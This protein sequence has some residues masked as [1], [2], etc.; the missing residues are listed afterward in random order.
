M[1][2]L[3]QFYNKNILL[4]P[5]FRLYKHVQNSIYYKITNEYMQVL[6]V[7]LIP[8]SKSETVK[9]CSDFSSN[10][11]NAF[12]QIPPTFL[13]GNIRISLPR[14]TPPQEKFLE[15]GWGR[16]GFRRVSSEKWSASVCNKFPRT[17]AVEIITTGK[18]RLESCRSC[19]ILA[20]M[21]LRNMQ[22][23][24]VSCFPAQRR[25]PPFFAECFDKW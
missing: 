18:Y 5:I 23:P 2:Y 7:L 15:L 24:N 1:L 19:C 3:Q 4:A 20:E 8:N 6:R 14:A 25:A 13:A 17:I 21:F 9:T 11:V 12:S 22:F 16:E 10:F